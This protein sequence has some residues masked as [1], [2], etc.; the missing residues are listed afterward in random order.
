[1]ALPQTCPPHL[2]LFSRIYKCFTPTPESQTFFSIHRIRFDSLTFP[3]P[4][5]L[6][7][8]PPSSPA[9][10]QPVPS[11]PLVDLRAE[12]AVHGR[13]I[14]SAI[15]AVAARGSFIL[16]PE[17]SELESTLS[18]YV[19]PSDTEQ[20][21]HC[22]GV[23]DGT[24]ALQICLQAL[25][26]GRGHQ[27]V[28]VPFT[29][30][31]TA[32]VIPLVG[33]TPVFAD[34]EKDSYL[35]DPEKLAPLLTPATRA[36]IV[37]S[38]FG[39]IP[40]LK[41]IRTVLD[42]AESK[43]G[44]RIAL[45]E[46]A[47]QSFGARRGGFRSCGAPEVTMATTSFFPT[48]PL[49]CYGDGGAVFTR[50]AKL[51]ALARALRVHGKI[52]GR[53]ALIGVNGRLDTIQAAVLLT[54]FKAFEE[55]I[56]KRGRAAETYNRLLYDDER[57]VTPTYQRAVRGDREVRSVYGVYTIRVQKR[58]EVAKRMRLSGISCAIYY[59]VC[60]HRQPVF[61]RLAME[62]GAL[63]VA[64]QASREVLSLPIHPY[65]SE[66]VQVRIVKELRTALDDLGVTASPE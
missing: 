20:P 50:N 36:V 15:T 8:M 32:E 33:A 38:L 12:Y 13:A 37:V 3:S 49:S 6:S 4:T 52:E 22:I 60:C 5:I 24:T 29:W 26:V 30:I 1:M 58:D 16:G 64:E 27:V 51:A 39:L 66:D 57:V 18:A 34:I 46:D 42:E 28:T 56:E 21:V 7:M 48:K 19:T 62:E 10:L 45:I 65:L 14:S 11:I 63:A 44:T 54:K 17:V 41:R 59:P 9:P 25:R 61:Q 43:F 35:I 55:M 47:A 31:S 53:H 23:S 2:S 40:D